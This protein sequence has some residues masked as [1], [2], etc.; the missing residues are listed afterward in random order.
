MPGVELAATVP[1][2]MLAT[3][4]RGPIMT[5]TTDQQAKALTRTAS[6]VAAGRAVGAREPDALA[7]NP[8]YLA[9]RFLGDPAELELDH[10]A[11]RALG[12]DYDE[13]MQDIEVVTIVRSMTV[14]TGFID[15][16]LER[17]VEHGAT[18][19]AILGAGFD[20]HAYRFEKLLRKTRVFE[21]DR[22]AMQA[23]KKLRVA[24]VLGAPP[25]NLTYVPVDFQREEL[26]E[27]LQR[28]GYDLAAR[29]FFIMEGLTMYLAEEKVR[30]LLSFAASHPPGSSVVFDFISRE[31]LDMLHAVDLATAPAAA[32]PIMQRFLEVIKE[33]PWLFGIPLGTERDFLLDLG[34]DLSELLTIGGPESAER[35][36]TRADGSQVGAEA[37][38]ATMARLAERMS[39]AGASEPYMSPEQMRAQQRLMAHQLAEGIVSPRH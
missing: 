14:R 25:G 27:V 4:S 38:A 10:P 13:A 23:L 33:E 8:D 29:T 1:A 26:T 2:S 20:S 21:I 36:L 28:H 31:M 17:A 22:P 11:V 24:E 3:S 30:E 39:E 18:Q 5:E 12:L 34:F 37:L 15:E 32:R 19:I 35:Y 6:Y 16:A 9:E 7:T